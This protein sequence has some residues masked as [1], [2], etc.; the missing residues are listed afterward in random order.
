VPRWEWRAFGAR[1]GGAEEALEVTGA[2]DETDERYVLSGTDVTV[3]LRAGLIDV[4][5]LRETNADGLERWEPVLKLGFPLV[6]ADATRVLGFIGAS[7]QTLAR[8][9]YDERELFDEVLAEADG[10]RTVQVHKRRG[11]AAVA[12]CAAEITDVAAG[13][14]ATRTL[15]IES[16]DPA[17]VIAA[18][19]GLR[20]DGYRNTSYPRGL[21]RLLDD[22]PIRDAVIDVGTNSVKFIVGERTP[23]GAWRTVVDRAE[24]TRLGEGA[25]DAGA[26]SPEAT[27]RTATAVAAMADEAREADV[28][29]IAAVGTA[30]L[31]SASNADDVI[32]TI[33][34]R[35]GVTVEVISGDEESR[36]AYAA[37]VDALGRT[38]GSLVVFD[39]GGGSS[40]FTFGRAGEVEE[41]FS[42]P[43]GAARFTERFGLDRAVGGDVVDDAQAAIAAELGRL[44]GRP[45]PD[46]MIGMGGA[47]TNMTAVMLELSAYDAERVQGATLTEAEVDGQIQRYR[48]L[49][50]D[51]RRSIVGLQPKRAEVILAGACIVR[52]AMRMLGRSSLTVSDRGLRQGVLAERFR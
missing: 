1:F 13:G 29:A 50:A 21:A 44:D 30:A 34:V 32:A 40:Q 16:E 22:A 19:R 5:V 2:P 37:A 48:A 17:A 23:D 20:L 27:E 43:V 42:V 10:V 36:L 51:E 41:R 4:K 39:S 31:R 38:G 11:H 25:D 46:E 6:A 33:L 18:V 35:S 52:T 7:T 24:L 9:S 28:R 26:I 15:A 12:G 8:G 3:K 45:P 47:I 14:R 49:P